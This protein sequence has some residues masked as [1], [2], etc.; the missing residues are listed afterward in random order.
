MRA[1]FLIN[2]IR[3]IKVKLN[4]E[5]LQATLPVGTTMFDSNYRDI[6]KDKQFHTH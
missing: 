1:N 2:E 6:L 5:H 3:Q 4:D